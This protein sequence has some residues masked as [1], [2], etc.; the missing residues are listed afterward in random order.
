MF[1]FENSHDFI[2][3]EARKILEGKN[4]QSMDNSIR[5]YL[6]LCIKEKNVDMQEMIDF[7]KSYA[8]GYFESGFFLGFLLKKQMIEDR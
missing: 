7:V 8:H 3:R 4:V 6:M 2:K 5:K 1:E